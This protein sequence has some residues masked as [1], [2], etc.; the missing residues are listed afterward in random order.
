MVPFSA[1]VKVG[2]RGSTEDFGRLS[3]GWE[4]H[5]L[6]PIPESL[7]HEGITVTL[8]SPLPPGL[9]TQPPWEVF[10]NHLFHPE[11]LTILSTQTHL[12]LK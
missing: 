7:R 2:G 6:D 11:S 1:P 12:D 10:L 4:A 8:H 3:S 9:L 5:A